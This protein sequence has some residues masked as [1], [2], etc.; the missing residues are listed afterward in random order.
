M[1]TK[2]CTG[3]KEE[4]PLDDFYRRKTGSVIQPCAECQKARAKERRALEGTPPMDDAQRA[5][6]RV[7]MRAIRA[8]QEAEDAEA[9]RARK[10]AYQREWRAR[11][12]G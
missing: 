1:E 9:Y 2:R 6:H 11:Q 4:R 3:C 8:K 12:K 5:R 10:A 7:K